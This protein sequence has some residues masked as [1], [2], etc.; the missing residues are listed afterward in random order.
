MLHRTARLARWAPLIA[1]LV[2]GPG[3]GAARSAPNR[4]ENRPANA[5][6]AA[7]PTV[8]EL[9]A[10]EPATTARTLTVRPG[11]TLGRLLTKAGIDL[12]E[13][14]PA[15]SAL[16]SL[17]PANALQPGQ[18]LVLRQDPGQ[19]DSLIG[20][21]IE[22]RPGH[23]VTVSRSNGGWTAQEMRAEQQRHLVLARGEVNGALFD[24]LQA[25]GLPSNLALGLVRVLAHEIDFQRD[26]QPGDGFAVLFERFRDADGQFLRNG[27]V[28]HAEFQLSGRHL[29][30]WRYETADGA[31]WY[32]DTGRSLRHTFLRT[33]LDG[34]RATSGFGIRHHP[35]LGFT[36][37]H[38][39]IDFAAPAGT[40]VYAAADGVV[41]QIGTANGYG[42]M[43]TLRHAGG[44]ETRYAHLSAFAR[45][46]KRGSRVRQGDVIGKVGSSGLATG[47]HLHY[48]IIIAGRP[49]NPATAQA[50]AS[51]QLTGRDLANFMAE[52]QSLQTWL[53]RLE[54]MQEVAA[55][56]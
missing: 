27:E 52:R 55:A 3:A 44:T 47:P 28:V 51:A 29:S 1:I 22:S 38:Q 20:L 21:E 40:P 31:D 19:D 54:P 42:R 16:T 48:E 56:E 23:V 10:A 2:M 36:R 30:I 53:A 9:P 35:V 12:A 33:P 26:L 4:P 34:A 13:A 50:E 5:T 45:G 25:A 18:E 17:F 8:A 46:L 7:M 24:S 11:D 49:V 37:M 32:D 15:L 6:P 41:E 39:G 43:V 14:E